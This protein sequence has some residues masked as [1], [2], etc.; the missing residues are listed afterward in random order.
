MKIRAVAPL[1]LA[2]TVLA[3]CSSAPPASQLKGLSPAKALS[4]ACGASLKAGGVKATAK[5]QIKGYPALRSEIAFSKGKAEGTLDFGK[6]GR[7]EV[8]DTDG[9]MYLKGDPAF[10]RTMLRGI[11]LPNQVFE[12]MGGRWLRVSGKGKI[13]TVRANVLRYGDPQVVVKGCTGKIKGVTAEGR[14]R[15]DGQPA[16][17]FEATDPNGTKVAVAA[18]NAGDPYVLDLK[19]DQ[20]DL[21]IAIAYSDYG[22]SVNP[23]APRP[24]FDL[25]PILTV[26]SA[27]TARGLG[28][29]S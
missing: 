9:T 27:L 2:A 17:R 14:G 12:Q 23:D 5:V 4:T 11:K 3:A 8:I 26:G 18:S 28:L 29:Y 25:T 19:L 16:L 13:A 6:G 10:W 15:V 24:S 20:E 7:A 21:S 22:V 1:V